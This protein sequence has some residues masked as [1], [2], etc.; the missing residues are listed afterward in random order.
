MP[1]GFHCAVP[2]NMEITKKEENNGGACVGQGCLEIYDFTVL[3]GKQV[4]SRK[5]GRPSETKQFLT[6]I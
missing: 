2:Y 1:P 4:S 5:V 3:P 6:L